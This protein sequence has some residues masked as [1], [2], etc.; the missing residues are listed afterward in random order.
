M[1]PCNMCA[2]KRNESDKEQKTH[3]EKGSWTGAA[4]SGHGTSPEPLPQPQE[5]D[6]TAPA[7]QAGRAGTSIHGPHAPPAG[8]AGHCPQWRP[9]FSVTAS[10]W[11]HSHLCPPRSSGIRQSARLPAAPR[12]RWENRSMELVRGTPAG[13]DSEHGPR[14][15]AAPRGAWRHCPGPCWPPPQPGLDPHAC[16]LSLQPVPLHADPLAPVRRCTV[17]HPRQDSATSPGH[18]DAQGRHPP[19]RTASPRQHQDSR[20]H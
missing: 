4:P 3:R 6:C 19:G 14:S 18:C 2:Q 15:P 8:H 16:R 20:V 9:A 10:S 17:S 5:R 11:D 7:S 12:M 13:L 1:K